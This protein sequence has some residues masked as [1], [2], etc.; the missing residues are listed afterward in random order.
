MLDGDGCRMDLEITD[1]GARSFANAQTFIGTA[2]TAGT[3]FSN[4]FHVFCRV[5]GTVELDGTSAE[6]DAPA[7]RDHSWG[8]RRWD[9]FVSSRSFGGSHGAGDD[10]LQFRFAS[11]VGANGSFFRVGSLERD[12]EPLPVAERRHAGAR[13]RRLGALPVGRGPLRLE[14]GTTTTVR[15]DTIGGMI[16]VTAQRYGWESVG[17]VTVDGVPGRLGFPRDQPQRAQRRQTARLRPGRRADQRHRPARSRLTSVDVRQPAEDRALYYRQLRAT[18]ATVLPARAHERRR[19]STPPRLVDR[20]LA[21]FIV[22]EEWG[23]GAEPASSAPSSTP[24]STT[25]HANA[26]SDHARSASTSCADGPPRPVAA[27]RRRRR[28]SDELCAA[29]LVDVERRFLER[30]DELR[31]V[32]LAET[33]RRRG[34]PA[35]GHR[36]LR[37]GRSS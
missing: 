18:V 32:V 21:E 27:T 8:V 4:N 26:A 36:V 11:M 19:R 22:E 28:R 37:H 30:V 10:A 29:D 34:S 31:R 6:V 17:D 23:D 13:R 7:W 1:E 35:F 9:S 14:D 33:A 20:I 2:G 16:G 3:I 15:I 12:G 24:C 25:R 5:R